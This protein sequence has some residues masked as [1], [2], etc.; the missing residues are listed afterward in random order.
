MAIAFDNALQTQVDSSVTSVTRA[1]T[2]T[3][4]N[5]CVVSGALS[6]AAT[7]FASVTYNGAALT[8]VGETNVDA[9]STETH[10]LVNSSTGTNNMVWTQGTSTTFVTN[11]TSYT[12]VRNTTY[13]P[14]TN[15]ATGTSST[16]SGSLTTL[17]ANSWIV[18]TTRTASG[19]FPNATGTNY[20]REAYNT[21]NGVH[22]G[23]S[24]APLSAGSNSVS[25][26]L[27]GSSNWGVLFFELQVAA[28]TTIKTWD[29]IARANV[30]TLIG[31]ASANIKTING[32][33]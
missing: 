25:V 17:V 24:E 4:V 21:A 29:G 8:K 27:S 19:A 6:T 33:A 7:D 11:A 31:V 3:G 15:T 1:F 12:G 16:I 10:F 26:G 22:L 2:V 23:S 30:K 32:I 9:F 13:T 18:S 20:V 14:A 28:T 5:T